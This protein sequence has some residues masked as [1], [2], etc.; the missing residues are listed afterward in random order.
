MP[1]LPRV[2]RGNL[3]RAFTYELQQQPAGDA[4]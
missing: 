4:K 1:R 3:L 2:K